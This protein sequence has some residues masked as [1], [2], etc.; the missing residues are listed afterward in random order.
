MSIVGK[1]WGTT[2]VLEKT[3]LFELH[4]LFIKPHFQCSFHQHRVKTNGFYVVSGKLEIG[5]QKNDYKLDDVTLVLPGKFTAVQPTE[6]H[7]FR[8]LDESCE[9]LEAYYLVPWIGEDIERRSVG[10]PAEA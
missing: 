1:V 5:V 9:C 6:F 8:T 4:R 7:F 2:E 10:G 3:P